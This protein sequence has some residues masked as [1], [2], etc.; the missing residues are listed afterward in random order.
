MAS[1]DAVAVIVPNYNKAK[2]LRACLD[3]I[4]AQT[5]TPME[6]IVV[7]DASTDGSRDIARGFP[8]TLVE[9]RINRGV[10]ATRNAGV[11][12]ST[13]PLLFFVDS[14]IALAPEAIENATRVLRSRPDHAM[15][16]GIWAAEPLFDDG[17]VEVYR[18]LHEHFWRRRTVGRATATMFSLSLIPRAVFVAAGGLDEELRSG[19]DVE[20]GT[21]LPA[22]YRT[23]VTDTVVGRHDDVDRLLPFLWEQLS[24]AANPDVLLKTWSRRNSGAA[25]T[26]MHMMSPAGLLLAAL[27]CLT[28][29]GGLLRPWLLL[30]LPPLLLGFLVVSREFLGFVRRRKSARFTVFAAGM[31]L[32]FYTAAGLGAAV[33]L[34]TAAMALLRRA[35]GRSRN[36][37]RPLS[38]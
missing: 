10:S 9:Q 2:T 5:R 15:V 3:A 21:R 25:G 14:D 13:A 27:C 23:V 18:L 24:R 11:A 35:A 30:L 16:Q 17:P 28:V 37:R 29:A 36:R 26:R 4:Y 32:L 1:L 34:S 20:F 12:A 8:C 7:D 19:E 6:V 31:H 38:T 33:G 22:R